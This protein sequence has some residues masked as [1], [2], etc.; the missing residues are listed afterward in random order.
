MIVLDTSVII[1]SL[2]PKL[3]E[4]YK[5]AE[6]V[7]KIVKNFQIYAPK[8]LKI[9]LASVLGRKKNVNLVRKFVEDLASEI[10]LISEEELFNI[11][12]KIAFVVKGRAADAYFI[13]TAKL[14]N[15]I[16]IT[17]DKIMANNAKK[18]G[19][20]GYYLIEEFDK[21]VERVKRIKVE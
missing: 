15:S 10:N 2:L 17:N 12:Y 4:R 6:E 13:A 3:G 8:I 14:T 9:E 19:V 16:L 11:A 21:V 1:D 18:A 5:K 20:E 7:L